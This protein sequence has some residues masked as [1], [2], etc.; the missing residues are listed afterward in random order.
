MGFSYMLRGDFKRART[1]YQKAL[2][3][4]PKN[5]VVLNNIRILDGAQQP[6]PSLSREAVKSQAVRLVNGLAH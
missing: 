6:V 3:L 1:T 2:Q 4:D 5:E